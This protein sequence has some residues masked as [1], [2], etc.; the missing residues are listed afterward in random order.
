VGVSRS[1][2]SVERDA[3]RVEDVVDF[4]DDAAG[5][6]A[7]GAADSVSTESSAARL[8]ASSV[9]E[10]D[11]FAGARFA[12]PFRLPAWARR[13]DSAGSEDFFCAM[14][15]SAASSGSSRSPRGKN[16]SEGRPVS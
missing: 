16:T 8:E 11:A 13:M 2:V 12:A 3:A 9:F 15:A 6:F 4:R 14:G 10:D 5:F 7:E 1:P